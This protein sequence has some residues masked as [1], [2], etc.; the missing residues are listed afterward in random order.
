[1]RTI[2]L[3]IT[4]AAGAAVL[5]AASMDAPDT[6]RALFD[7]R[8][9]P[10]LRSPNPSSCADCHLSGVDLK[11]YVRS[12]EAETFAAL[13]DGGMIDLKSPHDS[14]LL[15]LIRMSRPK[16]PLVTQT[17]RAAEYEAFR[18]WI[19]VAVKNPALVAMPKSARPAHA[20][21]ENAVVRHE[22]IDNVLESFERNVWSQQGRCMNCHT[23]GTPENEANAKKFGDRVKWFVPDSAE[24]TMKRILAQKLVNVEKPEES[25]LLLKPL[26]KVPHGGGVKF[27]YGDAG[28]KQYRAWIEDYAAGVKGTYR[29]AS[30]LP[31]AT[32]SLVY[33]SCI[34]NIVATPD[35]WGDKLLTV[36]VYATDP[37]TGAWS[38]KPIATGD[39]GVWAKGH[40]TNVLVFRTVA[41]GSESERTARQSPR[42]APGRYLLKYYCDTTGALNQDYRKPTNSQDFYQGDQVI[43]TDWPQ[44]W[45]SPTKVAVNMDR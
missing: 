24:E 3:G 5:A 38:A 1:M 7:R 45:G 4:V 41:P 20:R 11:D 39:R 33:T 34:L 2:L 30:D 37:A 10:I 12:T 22:R 36:E 9:A 13:R 15:K 42:L 44:G 16:T 27:I 19:D 43:T 29:T 26:N 18:S 14:H 17:A 6:S 28:Y 25:L 21:V 32:A 23:P 35:S 31:K 40:S 8:I